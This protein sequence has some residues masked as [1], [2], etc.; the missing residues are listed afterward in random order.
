MDYKR[1]LTI[2]DVSCIGQCSLTVAL[3][4]LSA[5]GVETAVLPSAVLSTHT[6]GF[7]GYTFRDLTKDMPAIADHWEK[8]GLFFDAVYT[9]Y[10]GSAE[11]IE[12]VI[13]IAD[14]LLKDGCPLI[15]DPAMAD[16]GKLY[17]G[18]DAAFV[19]AMKKLIDRADIILPNITEACLLTGTPYSE[20]SDRDFIEGLLEKLA[21]DKRSVVLTGVGLMPGTTGAA[22]RE[23]GVTSFYSHKKL[24]QGCH[25][26]GDLFASAFCGALLR[27]ISL[28]DAAGIAAEYVLG[29]I[30]Y[31]AGDESHRYGVKFE[32]KLGELIRMID[33]KEKEM[34]TRPF[35]L[36]P[37]A[38][39]YI[40]GGNRINEVFGKNIAMEPLAETWECSIH[41][42]GLSTVA[43]G[44]FAGKTL[45][46]VLKAHPELLG[47][48]N[49]GEFPVLIKFI[50]AKNKLSVQVHPDDAYAHKYENGQ[51][52]KTECWIVIDAEPG[53]TLVFGLKNEMSR[54]EIISCAADGSIESKLNNIPVVAGDVIPVPAG[55]VHAIGS[56]ILLAEVQQ[57]SNLTYRLYDWG[58]MGKD[59]KPR[60]LHL[61]KSADVIRTPASVPVTGIVRKVV[62]GIERVCSN[63]CFV[64][65]RVTVSAG[66]SRSFERT[67][68]SWEVLLCTTGKATLTTS[69]QS[70]E[71]HA[72][73]CFFLPACDCDAVV[74]GDG[75]FL[76]TSAPE[77]R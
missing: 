22:V 46:E 57:N 4:V 74:S 41:P 5:C 39:D 54:D 52:G 60:E 56:G 30:E 45:A 76:L 67:S 35:L 63:E 6:G 20:S 13:D 8:E 15:V 32:P 44:C 77:T 27:G 31:S 53:A 48:E 51:N 7:T 24:D 29:C 69:G 64:I 73:D 18:F 36:K 25:G 62:P 23:N 28:Y 12:Y 70:Y 37:A 2:Q 47:K 43:T 50:D 17:T 38:K 3:P 16:N 1:I 9:G 55:T 68:G 33:A 65:D 42:D 75:Q 40:W 66:A 49:G 72:G 10:L 26:T 11:Q 21:A 71:L 14:R 58:R 59:G 19:E 61:E 34:T